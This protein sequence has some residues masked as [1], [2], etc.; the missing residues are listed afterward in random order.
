MGVQECQGVQV[1]SEQILE[2]TPGGVDGLHH[3]HHVG[4]VGEVPLTGEADAGIHDHQAHGAVTE[5]QCAHFDRQTG[6]E[7][8]PLASTMSLI[9]R[10][11]AS[12]TDTVTTASASKERRYDEDQPTEAA[13][14][15]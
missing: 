3:G 14:I 13:T 1:R 9:R 4:G 5:G 8:H 10:A 12:Q 7:T 15:A 6:L 2:F 11:R